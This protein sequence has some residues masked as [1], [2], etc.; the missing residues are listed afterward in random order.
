MK[1]MQMH[2]AGLCTQRPVTRNFFIFCTVSHDHNQWS[3][4]KIRARGTLS[5]PFPF[6]LPPLSFFLTPPSP[7]PFPSVQKMKK[8][9]VTGRCVHKPAQCIC[10][11]FARDPV[12]TDVYCRNCK[13]WPALMGVSL[14]WQPATVFLRMSLNCAILIGK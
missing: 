6:P 14:L 2:C 1:T 8:F 5:P 13:G 10:W 11:D 3:N 12:F 7:F 4:C 9:L